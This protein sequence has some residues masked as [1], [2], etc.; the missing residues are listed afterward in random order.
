MVAYT[1]NQYHKQDG[2]PSDFELVG[3]V[4]CALGGVRRVRKCYRL[5]S[6]KNDA[7]YYQPKGRPWLVQV[8]V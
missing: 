4:S 7:L 8:E 6:G 1:H 2:H 3:N 5:A